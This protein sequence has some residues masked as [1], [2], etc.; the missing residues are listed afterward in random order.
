[1]QLAKDIGVTQKTAWFMLHRVRHMLDQSK[2]PV[3]F[4][5]V[6]E[7]DE[8][9]IGGKPKKG[10]IKRDANGKKY[11]KSGRGTKKPVVFG[12]VER[13]GKVFA[14]HITE[15][16]RKTIHPIIK[17]HV[18][19]DATIM[20]D[21]SGL[22]G[23]MDE[24]ENHKT[25]NHSKGE[26]A[27][28]DGTNTNTIEGFW[29]IMKRGLVGTYHLMS[30]KHLNRYCDEFTYRYSTRMFDEQGRFNNSLGRSEGRLTHKELVSGIR[31]YENQARTEAQAEAGPT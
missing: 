27:K 22:Y 7:M 10:D 25:V 4:N 1:M 24:Y 31:I 12:I 30:V 14:Q 23:G 13:N 16:N 21:E 20:T 5:A 15:A 6:V 17:Q 29:G 26:Y 19:P 11:H 9:Y 18:S 3:F 8:M 2:D 28:P